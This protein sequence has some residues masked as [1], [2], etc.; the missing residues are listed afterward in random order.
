[1]A[2]I[3]R[4]IA[5]ITAPLDRTDPLARGLLFWAPL[6]ER[7]GTTAWSVATSNIRGTFTGNAA[8][9][10][11]GPTGSAVS[12][13]ASGSID[14]GNPNTFAPLGPITLSI[15]FN[16]TNFSNYN[17]LLCKTNGGNPA[18][19]DWYTT[20][21]SGEPRFF[22]GDNVGG[23]GLLIATAP[24]TI[25]VWNHLAVTLPVNDAGGF[26]SHY[27][28]GRA[29]NSGNMSQSGLT[30]VN[31][32][33]SIMIGNRGDGVTQANGKFADARIYARALTPGEIRM[34][35]LDG[36]RPW[37]AKPRPVVQAVAAAA[38]GYRA[39][40]VRWQA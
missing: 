5:P 20:Q 2:F 9:C 14:F 32:T 34:L 4:S 11:G 19:I 21:G 29:N 24:P 17:G 33:T 40:V 27:L 23:Y 18:P 35:Y 7:G 26:C 3:G 30:G 10:S 36:L 39:R 12:M 25:G 16:P 31:G 28:N 15:W 13:P 38:P 22:L 1:M 6:T 8:W 37:R